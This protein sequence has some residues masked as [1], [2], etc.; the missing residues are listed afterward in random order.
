MKIKYR[1]HR[2]SFEESMDTVVDVSDM[3]DLIKYIKNKQPYL[4]T[5]K[6][7]EIEYY[8]IDYRNNWITF[9]VT[10]DG[11]VAGFTDGC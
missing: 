1:E 10:V 2:G 4:D 6:N 11:K 5:S 8:G 7:I 9:M 3:E